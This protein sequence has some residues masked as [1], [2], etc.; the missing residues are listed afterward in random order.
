MVW[1]PNFLIPKSITMTPATALKLQQQGDFCGGPMVKNMPCNAGDVG[2]IPCQ[3]TKI[4]HA[5]L[6]SLCAATKDPTRCH[7]NTNYYN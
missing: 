1:I 3:R 4:L 2:T 7:K 6:G 5:T